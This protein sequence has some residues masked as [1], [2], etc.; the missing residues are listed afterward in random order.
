MLSPIRAFMREAFAKEHEKKA[1][2]LL[3]SLTDLLATQAVVMDS[4]YFHGGDVASGMERFDAELPNLLHLFDQACEHCD[5]DARFLD[6]IRR[7][8]SSLQVY[9]FLAGSSWAAVQ[10]L[11][12]GLAVAVRTGKASTASG[13]A[14]HLLIHAHRLGDDELG[15]EALEALRG[16]SASTD[17]PEILAHLAIAESMQAEA[18]GRLEDALKYSR[19][20]V[21]ALTSVTPDPSDE[22]RDDSNAQAIS[23]ALMAKGRALEGLGRAGEAIQTYD[24]SLVLMAKANDLVNPGAVLHQLGNCHGRLKQYEKSLHCYFKAAQMFCD[25]EAIDH[26]GNAF[27]EMG[28]LLLEYEAG[29]GRMAA[30][31]P[32]EALQLG[33]EDVLRSATIAFLTPGSEFQAKRCHAALRRLLGMCMLCSFIGHEHVTSGICEAARLKIMAPIAAQLGGATTRGVPRSEHEFLC[34]LIDMTMTVGGNLAHVIGEGEGDKASVQV[35]GVAAMHA[36][37]LA[38][39]PSRQYPL[40]NWIA[41]YLRLRL[42][43]RITAQDL[44]V[45][46]TK[47]RQTDGVFELPEFQASF[48]S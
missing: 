27:S 3:L 39:W 18:E 15:V 14:S 5:A 42:G 29:A 20:A 1:D 25:M 34:M 30:G 40:L 22:E 36:F 21:E 17:D 7:I 35:L 33:A 16:L 41:T 43:I 11:R 2:A 6:P 10:L 28:Y 46:R 44:D 48:S 37:P 31:I 45:A 8:A 24:C 19:H 12:M 13:M 26:V 23:M 32:V 47:A 4:K 9:Y 38:A